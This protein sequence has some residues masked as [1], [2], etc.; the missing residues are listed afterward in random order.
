[1]KKIFLSI[2][3]FFLLV[4]IFAQTPKSNINPEKLWFPDA[5]FGIF[6]HWKLYMSHNERKQ[7]SYADF[8]TKCLA[9]AGKFT[10]KDYD[11]VVWAK[12]FKSWGAKY[13]VLTTKHHLG[14]SLYDSP[15]NTFTALKSSPAKRDLL[16]DYCDAMRDE[17][18]KVG[19]YFSLPDWFHKDY[20]TLEM[21]NNG[22][23]LVWYESD[24]VAWKRFSDNMLNEIAHLCKN[25]GRID[26][27][28]F[29][30]DWERSAALW[31]SEAIADT[32][33]KYQPWAVLNNRL[34]SEKVGDYGTPEMVVPVEGK[35]DWWELCTTLGY[36]WDGPQSEM[37][38]KDPSETV[39]IL[40]DV[41]SQGGN[42][43]LNVSPDYSGV[44]SNQQISKMEKLGQWVNDHSEA[45]YNTERGLPLGLF[46][47]ASTRKGSTIYLFAFETAPELVLKYIE[48]DIESITHLK[49]GKQ[50]KWRNMDDYHS[51]HNRKGWRFIALPKS[52]IEPYATVLK[53]TFKDNEVRIKNPDG[54]YLDWVD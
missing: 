24:L 26:L 9:E 54:S 14:F 45:I 36:N 1:M 12:M 15:Y 40:S 4:P 13:A 47:G 32:I 49:T 3:A 19:L 48:G 43:L 46:S 17:G 22:K 33:N 51:D 25:Y 20:P 42:L 10:A 31:R 16:N 21:K 23:E 28:W 52:L 30:G 39:R 11:P 29:D 27:F 7:L 38:L 2:I 53:I 34:R 50:L 41:I 44:I 5:K 18:L 35:N 37:G 6:V 8:Q